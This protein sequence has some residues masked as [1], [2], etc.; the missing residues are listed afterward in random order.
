VN[1]PIFCFLIEHKSSG[2]RVM[3]DLGLRKDI[4]NAAPVIAAQV[5]HESIRLWVEKDAAER[6]GEAGIALESI[7]AV[8]WRFVSL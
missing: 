5:A 8:I 6:L 1:V 7:D 2:Q 3:F 4:E